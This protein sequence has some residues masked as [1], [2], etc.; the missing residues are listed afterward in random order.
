MKLATLFL[1]LL[2]TASLHGQEPQLRYAIVVHGGAGSP[3]SATDAARNIAKYDGL[4]QALEAGQKILEAGGSSLDAVEA[5]IRLMEDNPV[6]NA[7]RGAVLNANGEAEL[8][9]SIMDG[10]TKKCGAVASA[11]RTRH[12]ITVSRLIMEK[13][14]HILLGAEG[15]D[16]FAQKMGAERQERSWFVTDRQRERLERLQKKSGALTPVEDLAGRIGTVGC[17]ALDAKG[18]LAAGTST[19]GLVNKLFGRIG[20]SPIIGAGT[21]ADNATCAVSG[22]GI[23]E[24]FI[25]HAVAYDLSARMKYAGKT[26]TQAAHKILRETLQPNQAGLIAVDRKGTIVM[27]FNTRAMACAAAD[28]NGRFEI[29]WPRGLPK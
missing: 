9:A 16:A 14:R 15:V 12:P 24:E 6:F 13:T 29:R 26:V 23:G 21:Y 1:L 4:K 19:G 22:T 10:R 5:A 11:T 8:D 7:G 20:D 25:R 2:A 3:P 28:S 18:N 17:V 27:D